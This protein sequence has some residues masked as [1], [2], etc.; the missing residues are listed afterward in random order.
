MSEKEVLREL[1][2]HELELLART[3][4]NFLYS[5]DKVQAIQMDTVLSEEEYEVFDSFSS[6][7]LR[8]YE[9]L[10]NQVIR[11]VLTLVNERK[12]TYLDNMHIAEKLRLITSVQ[13]IDVVRKLRNQVA[14]AYL[15]EEW[16][17]IYNDLIAFA[18][19][20]LRSSDM[21]RQYCDDL[22]KRI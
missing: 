4:R 16:I 18:P 7:F 2:E 20:L 5:L 12:T 8:L 13:D 11:T 15:D 6:R 1:L 17:S 19:F 9:V 21:T 3:K 14:H 22:A 10:V